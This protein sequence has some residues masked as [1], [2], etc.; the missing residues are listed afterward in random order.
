[1]YYSLIMYLII[2][3]QLA[4]PIYEGYINYIIIN[5]ILI[6]IYICIFVYNKLDLYTILI[7]LIVFLISTP[8]LKRPL[9]KQIKTNLGLSIEV[10]KTIK[11]RIKDY[12]FPL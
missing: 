5:I 12:L 4:I 2:L 6:I 7:L 8:Y 9:F 10:P 3:I 1:M 11:E